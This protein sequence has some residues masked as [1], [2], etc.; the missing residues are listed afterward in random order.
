MYGSPLRL[1]GEYFAP[2]R[3]EYT[4]VTDF[5][6]RLRAH[7]GNLRPA[8]A[9]RHAAPT[10]F[11]LKDLATASHVFLLHGALRDA[12]QS[13]YVCPYEVLH[14]SDK[15]YTIDY[16]G[17]EK[18]VSIDHLQPAYFLHVDTE[19]ASPPVRPPGVKT[20]SGR[21]VRFP[22]FLAVQRSQR[23]GVLW[24]MLHACSVS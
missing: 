10:T 15:T 11:I 19:P 23:V 21:R 13:P 20:C 22:D 3:D 7:I 12:L 6:S 17:S 18:T 1:P 16:Q 4:D 2:S 9:S 24:R 14:R 8:P 5:V